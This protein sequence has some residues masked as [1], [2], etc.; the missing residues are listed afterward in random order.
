[1]HLAPRSLHRTRGH[2]VSKSSGCQPPPERTQAGDRQQMP[3]GHDAKRASLASHRQ[4]SRMIIA[5]IPSSVWASFLSH[6]GN[7]AST[8]AWQARSSQGQC[9]GKRVHLN[10][11]RPAVSSRL[12]PTETTTHSSQTAPHGPRTYRFTSLFQTQ[13]RDFDKPIQRRHVSIPRH[14]EHLKNARSKS[15]DIHVTPVAFETTFLC[16]LAS[17]RQPTGAGSQLARAFHSADVLSRERRGAGFVRGRGA[18]PLRA[19]RCDGAKSGILQSYSLHAE[20]SLHR[21]LFSPRST[22]PQSAEIA[23]PSLPCGI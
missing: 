1:M 10:A 5:T 19:R 17:R 15:S 23:S 21:S 16:R 6:D 9:T 7:L 8:W 18:S 22:S 13:M 11:L 2:Q 12:S 20:E 14:L 4:S 3:S